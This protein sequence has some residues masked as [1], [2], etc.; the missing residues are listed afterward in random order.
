M[1]KRI[2]ACFVKDPVN[3]GRQVEV[4]LAKIMAIIFMVYCHVLW[5]FVG[6]DNFGPIELF[7]YVVPSGP[8]SAPIF[9]FCMGMGMNYS[10]HNS[11]REVAKRGVNIL[12]IGI[13]LSVIRTGIPG[14]IYVLK[15]ERDVTDLILEIVQVDILQFAGLAFLGIA[16]LRKLNCSHKQ[17]LL[18]ACA[19]NILATLIKGIGS[20]NPV[21][22]PIFAYFIGEYT[23]YSC[24]PFFTWFIIPVAGL[25]FGDLW[26][27]CAD[28]KPSANL[29]VFLT[30]SLVLPSF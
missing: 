22:N 28:K 11:V 1:I 10:R 16:L 4:D 20:R 29:L 15:Y 8:Y 18:I 12:I 26:K 19:S 13:V 6:E 9:M 25:V 5:K 14:I 17:M 21:L 23:E 7:F 24:F 3:T 30:L 27:R 2:K